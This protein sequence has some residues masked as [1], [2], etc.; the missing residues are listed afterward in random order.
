MNVS[1]LFWA[2]EHR[3]QGW[4]K[5]GWPFGEGGTW[6]IA[7]KM[8]FVQRTHC[9]RA[10][11]I[12]EE[13]IAK[14]LSPSEEPEHVT[15]TRAN[16]HIHLHTFTRIHCHVIWLTLTHAH[17]C[18]SLYSQSYTYMHILT[19]VQTCLLTHLHV[20]P[21]LYMLKYWLMHSFTWTHSW[22]TCTYTVTHA[23]TYS[24]GHTSMYTHTHKH[25]KT[26]MYL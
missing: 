19:H 26:T 21:H 25:G 15:D 10:E 22:H 20:D 24:Q 1:S 18:I 17:F 11:K 3:G 6:A 16:I 2:L 12:P 8:D 13:V 7:L 5:P 9:T 4:W 23:L 14:L